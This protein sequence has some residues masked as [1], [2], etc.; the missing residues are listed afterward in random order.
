MDDFDRRILNLVQR[1][2]SLT[3]DRLAQE[4]PLSPSAITRRLK[5][6]KQEGLIAGEAVMIGLPLREGRVT[7]VLSIQLD[8]HNY[9][10]A[11]SLRRLLSA[12]PEVQ[13]CLEMTGS[14]DMLVIA[15]VRDM[16]HFNEFADRLGA[17]PM[18]RRYESSFARRHVKMSL[19]VNLTGS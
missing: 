18:V 12:A 1:D 8:H 15:S 11:A 9:A 17:H 7:A 14:A 19:A 16:A 3:A 13:I 4:V 2:G 6:M 10:E 5:R